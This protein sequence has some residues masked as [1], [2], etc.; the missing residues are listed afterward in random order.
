MKK[1]N[2]FTTGQIYERVINK[3]RRGIISAA[4]CR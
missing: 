1:G 4:R 2:N 3:E